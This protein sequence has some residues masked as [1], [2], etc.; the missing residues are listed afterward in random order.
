MTVVLICV[1][2]AKAGTSWLHRQLAAHPECHFRAIKELHYFNA[3]DRGKLGAELAKHRDI[4]AAMLDR[5]ARGGVRPNDEQA[6]R[7]SARADW[8]DVIESKR[9]NIR[10]YLRYLETGADQAKVVGEM[11]P[12]YA[13]LSEGQLGRIAR[14]APDVRILYLMRE[15]VDRL[16]SHIRMIAARRD[17][18]GHVTM[19][20]CNRIL[21]RVMDGKEDQ[22]ARRSD[23]ASALAKL[24]A[25]IPAGK[26]LIEVFEDMIAGDA[27]ARICDF[28]GI[29]RVEPNRVPVHEGQ[30][31][32]MTP[33]QRNTAAVWLAPQYD[34]AAQA[35]GG[36]PEAWSRKG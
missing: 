19:Q 21:S 26:L 16:W 34:A 31:L 28:L 3:I 22:I 20:R 24:L 1:G 18:H 4:H 29:A 15:P 7:L 33:E 13:L 25:T 35:L 32:N 6:A 12:A 27:F 2:A 30:P 8:L 14:I 10:A 5:L 23:Y 11:T 36:M 17:A 9:E